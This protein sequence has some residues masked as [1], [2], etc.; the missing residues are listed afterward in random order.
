MLFLWEVLEIFTIPLLTFPDIDRASELPRNH[1]SYCVA[2]CNMAATE[3][4]GHQQEVTTYCAAYTL[5]FFQN[6]QQVYS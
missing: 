2:I 1:S 6:K 3:T 5:W 4:I